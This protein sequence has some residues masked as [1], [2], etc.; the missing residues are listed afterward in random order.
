MSFKDCRLSTWIEDAVN[1]IGLMQDITGC[2]PLVIGES[3]GGM[4][5]TYIAAKKLCRFHSLLL[6]CPAINY[7][8]SFT[9]AVKSILPKQ[10]LEAFENGDTITVDLGSHE[11]WEPF[12][13]SLSFHHDFVTHHLSQGEDLIQGNFPVR[14]IH[15]IDDITLPYTWMLSL[16]LDKMFQTEDLVVTL[17]KRCGHLILSDSNGHQAVSNV[18]AD[19]IHR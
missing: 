9:D 3:M 11:N 4:V 19:L 17:V 6:L 15:G 10:D 5:S 8:N 14:I 7:G 13:F 16:K 1:M 12:L 18:V 2:P